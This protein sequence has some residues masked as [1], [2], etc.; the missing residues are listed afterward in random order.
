VNSAPNISDRQIIDLLLHF[1]PEVEIEEDKFIYK[2]KCNL[3]DK[4]SDI[5]SMLVDYDITTLSIYDAYEKYC[6]LQRRE[7][8]MIVTKYFFEKYVF[9][10]TNR[11]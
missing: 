4:T 8:K 10:N 2:I 5:Q 7:N 3:W 1:Y 9:E 11:I 6:K